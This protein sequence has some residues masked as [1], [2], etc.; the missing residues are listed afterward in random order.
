[1]RHAPWRLWLLVILL[2]GSESARAEQAPPGPIIELP[3]ELPD[4]PPAPAT[5]DSP[6]TAPAVPSEASGAPL[7]SSYLI[8]AQPKR[9]I[10]S[11]IFNLAR[12]SQIDVSLD[13]RTAKQRGAAVGGYG[14]ATVNVPIDRSGPAIA[15]L[16]HTVLFF[17]FNFNDH[18]RYFSE[19]EW[20]HA[21]TATA[22][23]GEIA[24]EQMILD[25]TIRRWFNVRAG[26]SIIPINL[27]NLYHEPS[28]F[29]GVSRPDVDLYIVPSTWKQLMVGFYGAVGTLRYQIYLTPG[30]RAEGFSRR[31]GSARRHTRES[32][33]SA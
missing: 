25:F 19:I 32:A 3:P 12:E 31:N 2:L 24:V 26:M 13:P 18:I 1:M 17:G 29:N 5:P 27:V 20:E 9:A 16:A 23:K 4:V 7:Q 6:P 14:D 21:F 8:G 10:N 30:M 11:K 15:D 33:A 22:Q 28:T